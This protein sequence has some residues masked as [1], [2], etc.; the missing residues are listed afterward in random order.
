MKQIHEM[1][2]AELGRAMDARQLS[3]AE[4]TKHLLSRLADHEQ[5]G[6]LLATNVEVALEHAR[7]ADNRRADGETGALLG[8]PLAHKDIFVTAAL[9]TTAGSKILAEYRSPF[10]A[11]VV[12][13]LAEAGTVT[14]IGRAHV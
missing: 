4:A 2:V 10:D 14:Q 9:P 7:V 11:T 1:G 3:S 6:C 12:A 13:R 5:L 8:V